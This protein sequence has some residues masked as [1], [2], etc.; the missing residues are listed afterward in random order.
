MIFDHLF[1]NL[2]VVVINTC[3]VFIYSSPTFTLV[4]SRPSL[5]PYSPLPDNPPCY[6]PT[7]AGKKFPSNEPPSASLQPTTHSFPPSTTHVAN[8]HRLVFLGPSKQTCLTSGNSNYCTH[9]TLNSHIDSP[10][11]FQVC[12]LNHYCP[13]CIIAPLPFFQVRYTSPTCQSS[14]S[15]Q[16]SIEKR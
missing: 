2:V 6:S 12:L 9:C 15:D 4:L 8:L 11:H 7:Q 13:R 10:P 3:S 5:P 1:L 16:S 14:L